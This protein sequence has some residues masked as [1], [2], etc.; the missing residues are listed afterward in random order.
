MGVGYNPKIVTRG[1]LTYWDAGNSR[2]YPGTGTTWND[3]SGNGNTGTLVD[4]PTYASGAL[5]FNGSANRVH[6][7]SS[8]K[9]SADGTI[10]YQQM[11]I[12]LWVRTTDSVGR[13]FSKPWNGSGQYN[14]N[15]NPD[16]FYLVSGTTGT[17][18]NAIGINTSILSG[19]WKNLVC[20]MDSTNMGYYIDAGI[21]DSKA[22]LLSGAAPTSGDLNINL[23]L[24]SLYPYGSGWAGNASF[25]VN[26]DMSICKVY[27]RVLSLSEVR[28][29]YFALK[30]RFGL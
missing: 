20:W 16:G 17:T 12:S 23:C 22:H 29:N 19:T 2:S 9:W 5:T 3:L 18:S 26:G 4:G 25:S 11:T 21:S 14:I 27:N 28:Q 10:G 15:V 30:G 1:M 24:M 13:F 8:F 6:G 7:P